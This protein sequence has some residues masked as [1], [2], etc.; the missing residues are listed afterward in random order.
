MGAV[1][2]VNTE[3]YPLQLI[4]IANSIATSFNWLS[5]FVV[6][7]V[8]LTITETKPGKVYAYLI[9]AFF[10]LSAWI[11]IYFILPETKGKEIQENVK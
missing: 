6:S 2:S 1:W 11:F 7:S 8:F 3:I 9:L 5:N 10:S 4:G